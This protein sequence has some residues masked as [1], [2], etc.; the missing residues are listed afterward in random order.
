MLIVLIQTALTV[1][2]IASLFW[3]SDVWAGGGRRSTR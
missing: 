2:A 3:I 1:A